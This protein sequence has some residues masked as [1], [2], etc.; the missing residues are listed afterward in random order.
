MTLA[1]N[2]GKFRRYVTQEEVVEWKQ[3]FDVDPVKE[4]KKNLKVI[5]VCMLREKQGQHL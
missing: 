1:L 3:A 5:N 4:A 2:Y